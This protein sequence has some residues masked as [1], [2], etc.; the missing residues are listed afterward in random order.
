MEG[1]ASGGIGGRA[2]DACA[3]CGSPLAADQRYC[4]EC[5]KRVGPLSV[6]GSR[7]AEGGSGPA[8]K[9]SQARPVALPMGL[10]PMRMPAPRSAGALA[11]LTL[12]FG[13]FVG[14]AMG[15]AFDRAGLAA[16]RFLVQ[17]PQAAEEA[18]SGGGGST[19]AG[20]ALAS[21]VGN[22]GGGGAPAKKVVQQPAPVS[23]LP[24]SPPPAPAPPPQ[25]KTKSG[26]ND[27]GPPRKPDD[28]ALVKGTVVHVNPV[29]Q[30]YSVARD[31]GGPLVVIH[32]AELPDPATRLKLRVRK[33][34]NGTY[35]ERDK[36][37]D[38][39][40]G[41]SANFTATVTY[42]DYDKGVYTASSEG[43]S[44]LVHSPANLLPPIANE[45]DLG[46]RIDVPAKAKRERRARAGKRAAHDRREE[47]AE[48]AREHRKAIDGCTEEPI[49]G[50]EPAAV[51][52]QESYLTEGI[53]QEAVDIEGIVE[54]A[55]PESE[56]LELS[57]DDIRESGSDI[58]L[59]SPESIDLSLLEPG[60][61]VDVTA[62]VGED[63][64]YE[65]TGVSSDDGV[66][67]ADDPE[68]AQGD[69][70]PE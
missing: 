51:L 50:P 48:P 4:L 52:H 69:Q 60:T 63:G 55:C 58:A 49:P 34:F 33:L 38:L 59:P 8:L 14:L 47:R 27:D 65:L 18:V 37:K 25:A 28:K 22:V 30:S 53:A 6:P 40:T 67:G 66:A 54:G 43:A 10:P 2:G 19:S 70:E 13:V 3:G 20:A 17:L 68:T 24:T 1:A 7:A 64:S 31:E 9:S 12:A 11:A 23:S 16:G 57:A 42:V 41:E 36:P 61:A 29:A 46:V 56:E 39:G 45:L 26:G 44:V 15:P 35:A 62:V 5:G 32:A 21:P